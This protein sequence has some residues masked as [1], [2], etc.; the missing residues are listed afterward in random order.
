M[1]LLN[2]KSLKLVY[3]FV[4]FLKILKN[5]HINKIVT[6]KLLFIF[7]KTQSNTIKPYNGIA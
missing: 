2:D 7:T 6:F 3:I 5:I 1:F 4:L